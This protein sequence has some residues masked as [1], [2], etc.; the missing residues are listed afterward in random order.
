VLNGSTCLDAERER[1]AILIEP[2]GQSAL[3][4][5]AQECLPPPGYCGGSS[6]RLYELRDGQW[7][8]NLQ[9]ERVGPDQRDRQARINAAL[10]QGQVEVRPVQRR[11]VFIGNEAVG[12]AFE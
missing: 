5:T 4:V 9:S 7:A 6:T 12:E 10:R 1:C 3:L 2:G 8:Q 11:Q